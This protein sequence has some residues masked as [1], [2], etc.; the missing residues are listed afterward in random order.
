MVFE[1]QIN[2]KE[3]FLMA[4]IFL[5]SGHLLFSND[6]KPKF[7]KS[8]EI[9]VSGNSPSGFTLLSKE[10]TGINFQNDLP[11][12]KSLSN[13]VYLNGSGVALGDVNND[14][15]CDIYLCSLNGSNQLYL[16]QGG[17]RFDA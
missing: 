5:M 14:G 7:Y 16:N 6:G 13:Q 11:L 4:L 3:Y 8:S 17:W 1:S 9:L 2:N 15:L 10:K 12:E